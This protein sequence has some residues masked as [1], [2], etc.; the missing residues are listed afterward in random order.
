VLIAVI[1]GRVLGDAEDAGDCERAHEPAQ[2]RCLGRVER[3]LGGYLGERGGAAVAVDGVGDA[4]LQRRLE[5]H[6]LDERERAVPEL[7]LSVEQRLLIV[8]AALLHD[9]THGV[10]VSVRGAAISLL[11][12]N[13]PYVE[14][15]ACRLATSLYIGSCFDSSR[16]TVLFPSSL[17]S[18]KCRTSTT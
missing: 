16:R 9:G 10:L 12:Y 5:R 18:K 8:V 4:E 11:L 7:E 14:Y 13:V 6:G 17:Y 3:G 1:V 15:I 2:A